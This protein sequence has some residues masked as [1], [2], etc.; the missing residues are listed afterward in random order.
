MKVVKHNNSVL[1]SIPRYCQIPMV[2][3]LTP[4]E[5]RE[6]YAR[7][8]EVLTQA[9]NCVHGRTPDEPCRKCDAP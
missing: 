1:V 7:L 3:A 6:L 2:H 9:P 8:G 4:E 5:A